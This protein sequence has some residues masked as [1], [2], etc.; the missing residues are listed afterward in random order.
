MLKTFPI[1]FGLTESLWKPHLQSKKRSPR[2]L[3]VGKLREILLKLH[4]P[5]SMSNLATHHSTCAPPD[6]VGKMKDLASA[7]LDRA[8]F[9]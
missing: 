4:T 1:Y 6:A 2:D 7:A 9:L 3:P 8:S 5:T